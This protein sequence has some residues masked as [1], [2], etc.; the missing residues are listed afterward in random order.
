MIARRGLGEGGEGSV[1]MDKSVVIIVEKG[2]EWIIDDRN[3]KIK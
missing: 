1:D 2:I 3:N